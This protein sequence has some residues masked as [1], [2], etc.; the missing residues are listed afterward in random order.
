MGGLERNKALGHVAQKKSHTTS[1]VRPITS[2]AHLCTAFLFDFFSKIAPFTNHISQ[3]VVPF[4]KFIKITSC[5][6][7]VSNS[8]KSP[9]SLFFLK[10]FKCC[11]SSPSKFAQAFFMEDKDYMQPF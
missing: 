7:T 9:P 8:L 4:S 3:K 11:T 1:P 2:R 6:L 5:M 10:K